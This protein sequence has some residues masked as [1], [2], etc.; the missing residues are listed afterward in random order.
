MFSTPPLPQLKFQLPEALLKPTFSCSAA[1][2]PGTALLQWF[3][4]GGCTGAVRPWL[5]ADG[6]ACS[7]PSQLCVQSPGVEQWK[8]EGRRTGLHPQ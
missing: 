3:H 8:E 6:T 4:V 7:P 2:P 5:Q 1:V